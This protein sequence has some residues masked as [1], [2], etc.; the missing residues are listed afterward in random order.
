MR[1][2]ARFLRASWDRSADSVGR[3]DLIIGLVLTLVGRLMNVDLAVLAVM[4]VLAVL[5]IRILLLSPAAMWAEAEERRHN[6]QDVPPIIGSVAAGGIVNITF[7]GSSPY[8]TAALP[9]VE[10]V[11]TADPNPNAP[12]EA[13][14]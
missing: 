6:G 2:V 10:V 3:I 4:V 14:Q 11:T 5:L 8:N 9:Q 7:T 12:P 1:K 13:S